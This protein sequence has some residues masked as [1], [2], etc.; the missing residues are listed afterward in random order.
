MEDEVRL[1]FVVGKED[2]ERVLETIDRIH[3]YEEPAV[4]VVPQIGWRSLI[5][6]SP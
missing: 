3:P 2:L 6:P 4:D 1:E 5:R